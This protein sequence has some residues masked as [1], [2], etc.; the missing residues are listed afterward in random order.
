MCGSERCESF[1]L[2]SLEN[3]RRIPPGVL[4]G[5]SGAESIAFEDEDVAHTFLCQ[6]V[7]DGG[8]DD[9]PPTMTNIGIATHR[10]DVMQSLRASP[11]ARIG[12]SRGS[13]VMA[14][15]IGSGPIA[16]KGVGVSNPPFRTES[17]TD[18][19]IPDPPLPD[20]ARRTGSLVELCKKPIAQALPY[21]RCSSH[22]VH[23]ASRRV[24]SLSLL[25]IGRR[26]SRNHSMWLLL[27][28]LKDI[29]RR[30]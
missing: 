11:V 4:S 14:A 28:E 27:A 12:M 24:D 29:Q 10:G 5:R 23:R 26:R 13:G 9:P 19:V 15:A 6:V 1:T 30:S 8:A 17:P 3:W 2:I 22:V 21:L 25:A 18:V 16:R 7:R 20:E